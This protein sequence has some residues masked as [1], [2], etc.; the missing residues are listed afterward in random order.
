VTTGNTTEKF[1]AL[2]VG[3]LP[4]APL[5]AAEAFYAEY[6]ADTRDMLE[7]GLL[8]LLVIQL[9]PAGKD[10]DDWRRSLARDLARKYAP[11]RVNVIAATPDTNAQMLAYLMDAPGVTGQYCPT[12]D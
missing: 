12:D 2:E 8:E 4:D 3:A 1:A 10:H 5:D 6:L 9:P 7:N 11:T